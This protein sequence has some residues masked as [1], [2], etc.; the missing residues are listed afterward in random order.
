MSVSPG[1]T[2]A[3]MAW[4]LVTDPYHTLGQ[5]RPKR[6]EKAPESPGDPLMKALLRSSAQ[7][8]LFFQL[9]PEGNKETA[10]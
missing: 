5:G 3:G 4:Y 1:E 8:T 2:V 7:A 9:V 10:G 6:Y